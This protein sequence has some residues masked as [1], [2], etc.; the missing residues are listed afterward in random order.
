MLAL[1]EAVKRD[2]TYRGATKAVYLALADYFN[3]DLGYAWASQTTI[4]RDAGIDVRTIKRAMARLE[5]DGRIEALRRGGG[6]Y[7]DGAGRRHGRSTRWKING[8]D[9]Q[10]DTVSLSDGDSH[11]DILTPQGDTVSLSDGDS[12]SDIL[13]PQGDTVSLSDGDSHSDIL[14]PQGDILTPQ[15]D[16]VS[17]KR[18]LRTKPLTSPASA[19]TPT[20]S[21]AHDVLPQPACQPKESSGGSSDR[22]DTHDALPMA[23]GAVGPPPT[24]RDTP[25]RPCAKCG[26]D[27]LRLNVCGKCGQRRPRYVA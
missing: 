16:T 13:T 22:A 12:H 8:P 19:G 9:S 17:P 7:R 18:N 11:S 21:R 14:T 26:C 20:V 25:P 24:F 3:E 4:A 23:S 1:K 2:T 15:G 10:S 5:A 6:Q 27:R